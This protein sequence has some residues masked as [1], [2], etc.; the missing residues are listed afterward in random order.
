MAAVDIQSLYDK[1]ND[2]IIQAA[3]SNLRI[4]LVVAVLMYLIY[5]FI[6]KSGSVRNSKEYGIYRAIGVNRS[7]LLFKETVSTCVNNMIAYLVAF[8]LVVVLMSVRYFTGNIAFG[9]FI[10]IAA[11][12]F[13]V[14][15]L[16]MVGI[17]LIPYLF[18]LYK[19][20]SQILSSYDI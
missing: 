6:E 13:A 14:S 4:F 11:A 10:G 7:N 19:M 8:V 20:P 18:V 1:E 9:T 5:F 17:S 3:V 16:L 12:V 15:A 2:E